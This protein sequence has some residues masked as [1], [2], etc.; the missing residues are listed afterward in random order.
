MQ[1][2]QGALEEETSFYP[3]ASREKMTKDVAMHF[4]GSACP[5]AVQQITEQK[6]WYAMRERVLHF[7]QVLSKR[8]RMGKI[9]ILTINTKRDENLDNSMSW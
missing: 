2:L 6:K 7:D 8:G 9:K 3:D 4:Q 1:M 5:F